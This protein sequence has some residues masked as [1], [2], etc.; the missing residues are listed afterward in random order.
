MRILACSHRFHPD[1]GGVET[2]TA[3]L[4]S[5]WRSLGHEVR[6]VTR[7]A[8]PP[9]HDG[10]AV[11]R[12]PAPRRLA[13]EALLADVV[14]QNS[15]S[16]PWLLQARMLGRPVVVTHQTWLTQ[17]DGRVLWRERAKRL[18]LPGALHVAISGAVARH[19]GAARMV[20]LPNPFGG[21]FLGGGDCPRPVD[22]L[23]AGRMVSDKGALLL[24]GA[25]ALLERRGIAPRVE[26]IG[27]GPER[28]AL[29]AWARE[30]H[31][32]ALRM[33]IPGALPPGP[34]AARMRAARVL[35]VPS[36]W[37]EPLGIVALE[38]IAAG[39]HVV[40]SDGGGLPEAV[41]PCGRLFRRG[42]AGALA[43]ALGEALATPG[44][45]DQSAASA[46]LARFA[47][48]RVARAYLGLFGQAAGPRGGGP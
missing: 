32:R 44:A 37:E 7:S 41:G 17:P 24:A 10:F 12:N 14:W 48:A 23:F 29:E 34:L 45:P 16:L 35:A 15:I 40:A 30:T 1:V 6:I 31:G 4:A 25:L 18:A 33:S 43:D 11:L 8:G 39:C 27:D 28:P 36:V 9:A 26:W 5:E 13:H 42:S 2:T 47:P 20:V 3:V 38:G 21:G 46:H 19:V 22:L